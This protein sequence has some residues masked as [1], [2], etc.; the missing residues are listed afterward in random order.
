MAQA[1]LFKTE[2]VYSEN[3]TLEKDHFEIEHNGEMVYMGYVMQG[4]NCWLV[5]PSNG[6]DSIH[7]LATLE[8]AMIQLDWEFTVNLSLGRKPNCP[9]PV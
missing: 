4:K 5:S 2:I 6:E 9:R 1:R 7:Y 8:F 3:S